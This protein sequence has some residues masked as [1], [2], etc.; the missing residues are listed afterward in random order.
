MCGKDGLVSHYPAP[1][2]RLR[3]FCLAGTTNVGRTNLIV[4]NSLTASSRWQTYAAVATH[5]DLKTQSFFQNAAKERIEKLYFS[6][7]ADMREVTRKLLKI[8]R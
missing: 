2:S 5:T 3:F 6:P 7:V 8:K 4:T 1:I